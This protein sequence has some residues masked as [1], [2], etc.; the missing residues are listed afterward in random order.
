MTQFDNTSK[1]LGL[2]PVPTN[3]GQAWVGCPSFPQA[4][5]E[6]ELLGDDYQI[7]S[8]AQRNGEK[9]WRIEGEV[10]SPYDMVE[11]WTERGAEC[12][13][14]TD[15]SLF[16]DNLK[17]SLDGIEEEDQEAF[18]TQG[19]ETADIIKNL[20]EE[21]VLIIKDDREPFIVKRFTTEWND[22]DNGIHY[23]IAIIKY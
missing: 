14:C 12:Y 22:E 2:S 11:I 4:Q 6:V 15:Y 8:L 1:E 19:M 9:I 23:T 10:Y 18:M 17:A 5:K 13:T 21:D 16:L 3:H 7:V 20:N